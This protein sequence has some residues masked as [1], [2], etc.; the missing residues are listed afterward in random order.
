MSDIQPRERRDER[1]G[2]VLE[3]S[4]RQVE[5]TAWEFAHHHP[6]ITIAL[7]CLFVTAC[8]VFR[9]VSIRVKR[10]KNVDPIDALVD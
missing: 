3:V 2:I 7:A 10:V 5:M 4:E 1:V 8:C 9:P 6:W